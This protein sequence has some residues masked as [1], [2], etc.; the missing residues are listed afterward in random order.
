MLSLFVSFNKFVRK[1]LLANL[2]YLS[3]HPQLAQE[4]EAPKDVPSLFRE[5][6][7]P[8]LFRLVKLALHH[9]GNYAKVCPTNISTGKVGA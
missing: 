4:R 8:V 5:F 2:I 1:S 9:T 6:C 3:R 7:K